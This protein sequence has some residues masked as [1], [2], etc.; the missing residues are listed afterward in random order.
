MISL[1]TNQTKIFKACM[2]DR[3]IVACTS[4]GFGKSFLGTAV[5]VTKAFDLLALDESVP[6][7]NVYIICPTYDQ[8]LDIYFP[9]LMNDFAIRQ[10]TKDILKDRGRIIFPK[11]VEIRLISYEAIERM[12]GKGAYFVLWDEVSS[13]NRN[14]KMAWEGIIQPTITTRWSE[15]HAAIYNSKPGG[16]LF[17]STPKG[18]NFFYDLYL[19]YPH[20][21]FDYRQSPFLDEKEIAI[22]KQELD[23]IEF[24]S[25]Y[26]AEFKESGNSVF[27]CFNR[28]VHVKNV[29]PFDVNETIY[30]CIDFN[31]GVQATSL[32][33]IRGDEAHVIDELYG[34]P[35]TEQLAKNILEYAKGRKVI[36]HPD[37]TGRAR[38]TSAPV[39]Q[40]DFSIL[41]EFGIPC[42]ARNSPPIK[43]SV[44]VVNRRLH[45]NKFF[46]NPKCKR[47]IHSLER[48][49]WVDTH[50]AVID[51][52]EGVEHFSDNIR[53]GLWWHF[54]IVPRAHVKRGFQ[55]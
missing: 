20:F 37:P 42:L 3:Y 5:A 52:S 54:P 9:I 44:A 13:C 48:T 7:K 17:L 8:T 43:D 46:V 21:K 18:F 38:K 10:Y 55:F 14:T 34:A 16:A 31:V 2:N 23:P 53:Y 25:E 26:D 47:V 50:N 22:L 49:K 28:D 32:M 27:Y 15:K 51:K 29:D 30:A 45:Q 11:N 39:G 40:T 24:A 36:A 6:N 41:E 1:H 4:R 33:A 12:R 19:K 35:D